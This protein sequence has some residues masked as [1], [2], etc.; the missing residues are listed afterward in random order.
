MKKK[1]EIN[2]N[3]KKAS[4]RIKPLKR[5]SYSLL[6]KKCAIKHYEITKSKNKSAKNLNIPRQTLQSWINQSNLL[7]Y[8]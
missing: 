2:N 8:K 5:S 6:F 3:K 4:S 1:K 7:N